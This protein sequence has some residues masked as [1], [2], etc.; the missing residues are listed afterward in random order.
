MGALALLMCSCALSP[1]EGPRFSAG[2][3]VLSGSV[4]SAHEIKWENVSRQAL[5]MSCGPAALATIINYYLGDE[6]T[7]MDIISHM[8]KTSDMAEIKK[9][10]T[11]QAF[12]LL[13]LKRYATAK[14]Y[15]AAG[16]RVSIHDLIA[17]GKPAIIPIETL[18][19]RHFVVFKGL[20]GDRVYLADP[21]FGNTTMRYPHF[22]YVWKQRVALVMEG[23]ADNQP[24]EDHG[25]SI[26]GVK[27]DYVDGSIHRLHNPGN[28]YIYS[29]P[30]SF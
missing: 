24:G 20:R 19:Y 26:A 10:K 8:L 30:N 13:D 6:V 16:Y 17:F 4:T 29:P 5:D 21:A 9:I 28:F 27:G 22:M 2:G 18:G 14:G 1:S 7:E 11:R 15:A 23:R 25:L 3:V 12:S